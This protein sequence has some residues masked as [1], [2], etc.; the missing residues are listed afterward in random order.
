MFG[1]TPVPVAAFSLGTAAGCFLPIS[2]YVE[3]SAP[4]ASLQVVGAASLTFGLYKLWL[5]ELW[6]SLHYEIVPASASAYPLSV[7]SQVR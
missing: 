2:A 6:L 1:L 3:E 7:F 5:C 4:S